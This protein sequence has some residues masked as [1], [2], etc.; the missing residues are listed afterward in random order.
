MKKI[1]F[2]FLMICG[3]FS[4]GFLVRAN[5]QGYLVKT[6]EPQILLLSGESG[7]MPIGETLYRADSLEAVYRTMTS[8]NIDMI[9]EDG[10][11]SLFE[12][13]FPE[14]TSDPLIESQWY[15]ESVDAATVRRA[16]VSGKGV[17]IAVIDSGITLTHPDLQTAGI[18]DGYNCV[19]GATD[20]YDCSDKVGHG[21][22]VCGLIVAQCDNEI[23]ICG[24]APDAQI[25]PIKITEKNSFSYSALFSGLEQA[26]KTDCDIIHMSLGGPITDKNALSV[27][28]DYIRQ[29]EEKGI[30][31]V[32]AAGNSG[33]SGNE[34]N[35][36][37][38]FDSVIGVGSLDEDLSVSYFS[39]KNESVFVTAPGNQI[40][41]LYS[42]GGYTTGLGTS[43]SAPM[44]TAA[45]S[46][47]K[48]L[49][50]SCSLQ[51]IKE[52]LQETSVDMGTSGYDV[53]YGYGV[54]NVKNI[55]EELDSFIPDFMISQGICDGKKR[56]HIHN[57]SNQT[58]TANT[59]LASADGQYNIKTGLSLPD[60]VT[61]I[62]EADS[63]HTCFLWDINLRPYTK[64]Y[65][66]K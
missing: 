64:K 32:A 35:Y 2:S 10:E 18:S 13:E 28:E 36:P 29:A 15:L 56:I 9:F 11:L 50:P 55:M 26:L 31:V 61:D 46:L 45:I 24:L 7:I 51:Q 37:A 25:I 41:S 4:V 57:N 21:T 19:L 54:L 49:K 5:A 62:E 43:L 38:A 34:L 66:I 39:Q 8:D 63:Y 14:I 23:G 17:K 65:D 30:I 42:N 59:F 22:M 6:K 58:V 40:L 52:I 27:M 1:L 12:G 47:I 48:E 44:V 3:L 53:N 33:H 60:G 16:G 20:P